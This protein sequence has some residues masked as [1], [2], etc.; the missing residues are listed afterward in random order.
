MIN[1]VFSP[2]HWSLSYTHFELTVWKWII[3]DPK[4]HSASL[5]SLTKPSSNILVSIFLHLEIIKI[6]LL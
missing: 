2:S 5:K 1:Y 3:K 4:M 6:V